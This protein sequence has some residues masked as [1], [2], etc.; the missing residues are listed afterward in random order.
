MRIRIDPENPEF[1]KIETVVNCLKD[2]GI[3][4]YPTDTIYGIGC[5]I[6]NLRA[7]ER[8]GKIK[9]IDPKKTNMSFVCSSLANISDFVLPF[10]R[11]IFKIM[12]KNLPGPFT[13]VLKGSNTV[14]KIFKNNK[15]TVGIR[16]PNHKVATSIVERLE[17]PILSS[18][19]NKID[20]VEEYL[21]DPD[22][23]YDAYKD[24]VD[25]MIDGGFGN[26]TGSTV[27]DCSGDSVEIL[28]QGAGELEY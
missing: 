5:D 6:Y 24:K 11:N 19:L 16:V 3:I 27:V 18:S 9:G 28:R 26:Y 17:H 23:I 7:I 8:I 14:P 21:V 25:I 13:F 12:N 22:L 1:D 2:G 15:K 10:N 20:D 4:V